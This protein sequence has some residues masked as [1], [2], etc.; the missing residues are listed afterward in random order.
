MAAK[1]TRIPTGNGQRST[2]IGP[3]KAFNDP[4]RQDFFG[5]GDEERGEARAGEG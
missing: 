3:S 1:A 5:R 2:Q 4:L